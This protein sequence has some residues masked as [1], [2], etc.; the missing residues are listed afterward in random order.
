MVVGLPISNPNRRFDTLLFDLGNTLIYFEGEWGDVLT[1]ACA[2][3]H[4]NL[5]AQGFKLN[6]NWFIAK[7][8]KRLK[9][10]Y[11][12]RE[13][14]C[15]E[16]TTAYLLET[17]MQEAGYSQVPETI[18]REA[19][20]ALYSVTQEH[21]HIE[22]DTIPVLTKLS[23]EGYTLGIISNAGD[24]DDIQNLVDKAHIRPYFELIISSAA[25]GIRKPDPR[26]FDWALLRLDTAPERAAMIGDTLV[27]DILGAQNAN[28]Y[29]IFL[30]RR[31]NHSANQAYV[32]RIKPDA[33]I[34]RLSDLRD[35]LDG[36]LM[37]QAPAERNI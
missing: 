10:Y 12:E 1:R 34:H 20:S 32:E 8:L 35:L 5:L 13:T 31:T 37:D 11:A 3:M 36:R 16:L 14:D 18:L 2:E 27:A 23:Q 22:D 26:I 25:F 33:V 30:T 15:I 28:I 9:A 24:D 7:F 4:K 19:L 29:S 17:L 21:W 6:G